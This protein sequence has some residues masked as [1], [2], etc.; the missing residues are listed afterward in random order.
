VVAGAKLLLVMGHTS[1]G[2]VNAAVD[3]MSVDGTIKQATGC[4]NL[5]LLIGA[6]QESIPADQVKRPDQWRPDEKREF[7][8]RVA[9]RNV[10]RMIE[11]IREQ[12]PALD[13]MIRDGR[14]GIAGAMYDVRTGEIEFLP[15]G[16][17]VPALRAP[18]V[19]SR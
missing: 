15:I 16:A 6:I 9:R 4:D 3:L 13:A 11:L 10:L 1:C 12:S 18:A 19:E 7:A 14:I 2:A 17:D 5:D 8:D